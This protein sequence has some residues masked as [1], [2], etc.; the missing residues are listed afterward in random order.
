LNSAE[1]LE[2]MPE[3]RVSATLPPQDIEAI[4][5]ALATIREKLPFLLALTPEE[6]KS[7]NRMGDKSRA[8]VAKAAEVAVQHPEI[9]PGVFDLQEMQDDLALFEALYPIQMELSQLYAMVEDTTAVAG[10]EAF[11][12][13]RMVYNYAKASDMEGALEPLLQDLGKR[14]RKSRRKTSET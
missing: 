2:T 9:L 10:S 11:T 13:A 8:F 7:L 14:F 5:A 12:A 3:N 4:K 6:S 1:E